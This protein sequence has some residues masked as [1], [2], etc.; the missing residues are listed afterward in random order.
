M[1]VY[2]VEAIVLRRTNLGEADRIVTLFTREQGR[3]P[4]V[5][6]GARKPKSRFAGRLELFTH[7]RALLAQG[8]TLDV[9]SQVEVI[10]PFAAVR[11]D[12]ERLGAAS[13]LAEVTDRALPEREPQPAIFA[14]LRQALRTAAL[15]DAEKAGS[16][17][18]AQFLSLSGYGPVTDR[19]VV[20]GRPI[21]GAAA[22]SP[23]LGGSLCPADR[24]RDPES[25]PASAVALAAIGFLREMPVSAAG[26]VTLAPEQRAEVRELLRRYL[27]YRLEIRLKSTGVAERLAGAAGRP[28]RGRSV[29]ESNLP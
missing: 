14:A 4:A 22:F 19:C 11:A 18:A 16:W 20:C 28:T 17:Y 6:K 8:R 15:G 1:P 24:A 7:L 12:L 29:R 27:E 23:A 26:R 9:V 10:D 13:F 3:L 25:I 5:A 2:K 21:R